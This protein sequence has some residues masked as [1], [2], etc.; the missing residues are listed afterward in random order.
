MPEELGILRKE[1]YLQYFSWKNE[2][3]DQ[4]KQV[5]KMVTEKMKNLLEIKLLNENLSNL[6]RRRLTLVLLRKRVKNCV[7]LART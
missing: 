4:R 7:T 3:E 6:K 5:A 1:L 2:N